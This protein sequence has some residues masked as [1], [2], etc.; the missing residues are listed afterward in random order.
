MM[1]RLATRDRRA[2]LL[3]AALL[4]PAL[5]LA[6][7]LPVWRRWNAETAARAETARSQAVRTEA[8]AQGFAGVVDSLDARTQRLQAVTSHLVTGSTL[9]EAQ[10]NFEAALA[11]AARPAL[12]RL[13]AVRIRVDSTAIAHGGFPRLYAEAQATAD[14]TGIALF[15][16]ALERG[17]PLLAIRQV[18]IE[19]TTGISSSPSTVPV[20][21]LRLTVTALAGLAAK[22]SA[23]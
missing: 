16:A 10:A 13:D 17:S 15:L 19:P 12:V 18:A 9:P 21:S 23:P 1:E 6:R 11:E 3:G 4:V 2:V 5:V 22:D 20:L 7:G 8:M 14:L